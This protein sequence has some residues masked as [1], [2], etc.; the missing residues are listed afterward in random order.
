MSLALL[1][2]QTAGPTGTGNLSTPVLLANTITGPSNTL[3]NYGA[4]SSSG[5][6]TTASWTQSATSATTPVSVA[7]V[8]SNLVVRL[9]VALTG[10][11]SWTFTIQKNGVDTAV[12]CTVTSSGLIASDSANTVTFA[13]GDTIQIKSVPTGTPNAQTVLAI[14]FLFT[15]SAGQNGVFFSRV[16]GSVISGTPTYSNLGS[17]AGGGASSGNRTG[18]MPCTGTISRMDVRLNN[19]PGV[20]TSRTTTLVVNGVDTALTVIISDTNTTGSI[21]LGSPLTLNTGDSFYI[22]YD[23]TSTVAATVCVGTD[24]VPAV[25]GDVPMFALW[26]VNISAGN[27]AFAPVNGPS[28]NAE[29]VEANTISIAPVPFSFKRLRAD[30]GTQPGNGKGR[31]F[32]IRKNGVD[33]ATITLRNLDTSASWAVNVGVTTNDLLSISATPEGTSLNASN[34][35]RASVIAVV[36]S[37]LPA[38]AARL[39]R[40]LAFII[41]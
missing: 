19:A 27:T 20:G 31:Y 33:A 14:S 30:I 40:A 23:T 9:P 24:W 5:S 21:V 26:A 15:A 18:T 6:S 13:V 8:V 29:T 10:G 25:A 34:I 39:R 17:Q 28:P 11:Q 38:G 41:D 16:V 32:G 12:T 22:R 4:P 2:N 3:T 35:S 37:S 7:G 36:P 1:F